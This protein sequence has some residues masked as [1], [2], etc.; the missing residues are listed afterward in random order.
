MIVQAKLNLSFD[1]SALCE[2]GVWMYEKS[3]TPNMHTMTGK[4]KRLDPSNESQSGHPHFL[5]TSSTVLLV[6]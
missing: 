3:E 1:P 2:I 5:I 4:L 6:S